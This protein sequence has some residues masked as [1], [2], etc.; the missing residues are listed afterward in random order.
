MVDRNGNGQTSYADMLTM[1]RMEQ[2]INN[3]STRS[4]DFFKEN[5]DPRRSVSDECGFPSEISLE[6]YRDMFQ[7]N[8]IAARVVEVWPRL[9]WSVVPEILEDEDPEVSTDFEEAWEGVGRTLR[10]E[11]SWLDSDEGNPVWELLSQADELSGIG[12][13]GVILLG[14]D[15][16]KE[17]SEPVSTMIKDDSG[18]TARAKFRPGKGDRVKLLY[19]RALSEPLVQVQSRETDHG[20]VRFSLPTMY[21]IRL[22]SFEDGVNHVGTMPA[23]VDFSM[24]HWSRIIHVVD[25]WHTAKEG[26]VFAASRMQCVWDHLL[27]LRKVHY[28]DAEAYWKNVLMK[29]FFETHPQLGGDVNVDTDA[30]K[31]MMEEMGNG[32]Q[33][34]GALMGMSAKSVAPSVV[35]PTAHVDIH[36]DAICVKLNIPKRR[37]IGSQ[38]GGMGGKGDAESADDN[39]DSVIAHR[40]NRYLTPKLIGPFIDRL[41]SVGVLPVPE[42]GYKVQ[43]PDLKEE[44]PAKMAQTALVKTQALVAYM[45]GGGENLISPM[46]FLTDYQG[47]TDDEAEQTLEETQSHMEDANPD[48]EGDAV[49]GHAPEPPPEDQTYTTSPGQAVHDAD[50]KMIAENPNQAPQ[51]VAA[52]GG[53]PPF[54]KKKPPPTDN[55]FCP[56]GEGGGVD[57]T[58]STG[59]K[60]ASSRQ[61]DSD[62]SKPVSVV[63]GSDD[64]PI[65]ALNKLHGRDVRTEGLSKP[66]VFYHVTD[67][68]NM[69]SIAAGGLK[70][71]ENPDA[72]DLVGESDKE[73][74]KGVYLSTQPQGLDDHQRLV[75]VVLTAGS[76]I[77][78]DPENLQENKIGSSVDPKYASSDAV[79]FRGHIPKEQVKALSKA[80]YRVLVG[81]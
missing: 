2:M 59:G 9:S 34:W 13:F 30:L 72:A 18:Q 31:N 43:W 56:T 58:C 80:Q 47:M 15:D 44:D 49:P 37:F 50:G 11:D 65:E 71:S 22:E 24:V 3:L 55:V 39:T 8:A 5:F 61:K 7:R 69:K 29:M 51:P 23:N 16:G 73:F 78:Y 4:M 21:N 1:N 36:I 57:A 19:A 79:I 46:R 28:G 66:T 40:Q 67:V 64:D 27:S 10:G 12:S 6:N 17:L 26:G 48:M 77:D 81:E 33:G 42:D 74:Y 68:D 14:F 38:P 45:Q 76:K 62:G 75:R 52:P 53:A 35:E 60:R 54:G 32:L 63:K 20:N 25:T 41:I 70:M